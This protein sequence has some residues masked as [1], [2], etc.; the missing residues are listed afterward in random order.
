MNS[1]ATW[2]PA[3]RNATG[4]KMT[5]LPRIFYA[6]CAA[7]GTRLVTTSAN[8][9]AALRALT[10]GHVRPQ[11]FSEKDTVISFGANSL[12]AQFPISANQA[13]RL[14]R[15]SLQQEKKE[16]DKKPP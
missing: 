4:K 3:A 13:A 11:V 7:K 5:I 1:Y 6:S 9:F 10:A 2:F 16:K 15:K 12:V 14:K 8:A